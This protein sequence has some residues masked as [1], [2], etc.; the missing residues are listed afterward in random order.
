MMPSAT[1]DD[2]SRSTTLASTG[3]TGARTRGKYTFVIRF[4]LPTRLAE[5][6]V[7]EL[8]KKTQMTDPVSV[9][10]AYACPGVY[11]CATLLKKSVNTIM[12]ITGCRIAQ[13]TP[14]NVCL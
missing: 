6:S 5:P 2:S 11:T 4:A 10:G 3:P 7:T 9:S 1:T 14:R 13:V 8:A 12:Y